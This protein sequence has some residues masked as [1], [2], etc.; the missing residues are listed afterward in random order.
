M[1]CFLLEFSHLCFNLLFGTWTKPQRLKLVYKQEGW[2]HRIGQGP[3][4][5]IRPQGGVPASPPRSPTAP[6]SCPPVSRGPAPCPCTPRGPTRDR[7]LPELLC[8][9]SSEG[10]SC[11]RQEGVSGCTWSARPRTAISLPTPETSPSW[12][13]LVQHVW[14]Q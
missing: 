11:S 5:E 7:G 8:T 13:L 12:G 9:P 14:Q 6:A 2:G 4:P 1:S 10:Q 3:V